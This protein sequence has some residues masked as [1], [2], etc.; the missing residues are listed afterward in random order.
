MGTS[1]PSSPRIVTDTNALVS[2]ALQVYRNHPNAPSAKLFQ[3]IAMRDVVLVASTQT[4]YEIADKLGEPQL[5][6][7]ATFIIGFIDILA[8]AAE[9]VAIRGLDMGC[10]DDSDD[11]MFIETAV[12]GKVDYLI[13]YDGDLQTDQIRYDLKKRN[14]SICTIGQFLAIIARDEV[15]VLHS[16]SAELT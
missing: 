9:I 5:G 2:A 4:L 16:P 8:N 13:T 1:E 6:L 3:L 15:V 14:C 7:P 12:N 11:N 10:K